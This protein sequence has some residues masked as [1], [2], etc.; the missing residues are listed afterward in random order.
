MNELGIHAPLTAPAGAPMRNRPGDRPIWI[1]LPGGEQAQ[2][3]LR[4]MARKAAL[5]VEVAVGLLLER[6]LVAAELGDLWDMVLDEATT[7]LGLPRLGPGE[8]WRQW[9]SQLR[10]GVERADDELPSLALPL[11][12]LAQIPPAEQVARVLD[13]EPEKLIAARTLDAA[14]A[15]HGMTMQAWSLRSALRLA[16]R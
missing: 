6:D 5:P 4:V 8:T 2:K 9:V 11:R 10:H 16:T 12:V 7:G 14:A 1:E 15:L 13:V 3:R